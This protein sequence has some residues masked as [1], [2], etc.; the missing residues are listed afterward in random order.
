VQRPSINAISERRNA[1]GAWRGELAAQALQRLQLRSSRQLLNGFAS[2]TP[3][4]PSSLSM[5]IGARSF[6]PLDSYPVTG[7]PRIRVQR[8]MQRCMSFFRRLTFSSFVK[9][10][11]SVLSI[12]PKS[13]FE[14]ICE[15][16]VSS[17]SLRPTLIHCLS[18]VCSLDDELQA[19]KGFPRSEILM[20]DS[21][22]LVRH[23]IQDSSLAFQDATMV[24]V[25]A[26]AILEV[27][28]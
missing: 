12:G 6:D 22:T 1:H 18:S 25:I 17:G 27:T 28:T 26:L 21:L 9:D 16:M 23:K 4:D 14:S 10:C 7:L 15:V 24:A 20:R 11:L 8:L 5:I 13:R 2:N 3:S 19:G